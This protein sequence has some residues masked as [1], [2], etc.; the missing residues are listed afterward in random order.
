MMRMWGPYLEGRKEGPGVLDFWRGAAET[1]D[2]V[3]RVGGRGAH[4]FFVLIRD[5]GE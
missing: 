5:S 2:P 4:I 1:A 3:K